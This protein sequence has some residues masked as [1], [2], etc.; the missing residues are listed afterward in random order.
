[1]TV[2]RTFA[3]IIFLFLIPLHAQAAVQG[4]ARLSLVEGNVQLRSEGDADWLP[5]AVNTPLIEGD[6]VWCP[7]GSRAE[8]QL[9]DGSVVR[10]DGRTSLEVVDLEAD[11]SRM[12]LGMGHIYVSTGTLRERSLQFDVYETSVKV[13]DRAR[14]RIDIAADGEEEVSIF[15]GSVYVEGD[16]GKT[17]VRTGEMLTLDEARSEVS[18]LN[19]PDAWERW[20]RDRDRAQF[21]RRAESPYLPEELAP[22][23]DDLA[24]NG[25]WVEVPEYG[26]C[27]Q[28]TSSV[29][30]DWAPYRVGRWVWRGDDYVWISYESWGWAPYHYG[31]WAFL[32]RRGWCWVPPRRGEVFWAPGYVGWVVTSDQVGWV[33]LAPGE[34]Y[35]GRGDYG[36]TSVN[37][38]RVNVTNINATRVVYRNASVR[39]GA[40]FVRRDGFAAGKVSYVRPRE[41]VEVLMRRRTA[42]TPDFR[43]RAPEA[44][45]PV[46]KPVP[47]SEMPPPTVGRLPAR[48]LRERMPRLQEQR[49]AVSPPAPGR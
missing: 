2:V 41:R 39:N 29:G 9:A 26:Y 44:R 37:I 10:L 19:P 3:V 48:E 21:E 30:P 27:W 12:Y 34:V 28:P 20:N 23:T 1:M 6:S 11:F 18:P 43:P 25:R 45:M 35:Y 47:R 33:P 7:A 5:A 13:Y 14:F 31:R 40:M 36:P 38:T 16:G 4:F 22:Y 15:R 32:P 24:R 49:P 8:V 42:P 46:V 17:R